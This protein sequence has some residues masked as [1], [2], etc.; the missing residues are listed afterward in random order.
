MAGIAIIVKDMSFAESNLG[1][2]TFAGQTIPITAIGISNVSTNVPLNASSISLSAVYTPSNTTQKGVTW[3]ITSGGTYASI[4]QNGVVTLHNLVA[5]AQFTVKVESTADASINATKTFTVVSSNMMTTI[6]A[7]KKFKVSTGEWEDNSDYIS[8]DW[9]D[10]LN[11]DVVTITMPCSVSIDNQTG[12]T[13]KTINSRIGVVYEDMSGE[14]HTLY[15]VS[16]LIPTTYSGNN[17]YPFN[18]PTRI[19]KKMHIFSLVEDA[20]DANNLS[21]IQYKLTDWQN[22]TIVVH[23][24]ASNSKTYDNTF[25]MDSMYAGSSLT[26]AFIRNTGTAF[27][28][29]ALTMKSGDT[30]SLTTKG[31]NSAKAYNVFKASDGTAISQAAASADYTETPFTYTATED[32]IVTGSCASAAYEVFSVSVIHS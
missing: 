24:M 27:R 14:F 28:A 23:T 19:M 18:I 6:K 21:I 3:S 13:N 5:N 1:Q 30:L 10:V 4:N 8:C 16:N 2:V 32:V 22:G 31:G 26:G 12:S 15:F 9:I 17:S 25:L 7:G 11:V 20:T 29:F